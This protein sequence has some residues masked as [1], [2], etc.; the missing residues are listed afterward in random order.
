[1]SASTTR[2][3][4]QRSKSIEDKRL[5]PV[6]G[7]IPCYPNPADCT[8]R[9][10]HSSIFSYRNA[11]NFQ[12]N[13]FWSHVAIRTAN[14]QKFLVLIFEEESRDSDSMTFQGLSTTIRRFLAS[15]TTRRIA[16]QRE[17]C[18]HCS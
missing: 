3:I 14:R 16:R 7:P 13:F 5:D 10:A 18:R 11:L 1:M 6:H 15:S 8:T 4:S 9:Q 2:E 17:K 12:H